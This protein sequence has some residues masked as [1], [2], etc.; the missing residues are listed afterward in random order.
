VS[1]ISTHLFDWVEKAPENI[2]RLCCPAKKVVN[3]EGE[4]GIEFS[5]GLEKG[6]CTVSSVDMLLRRGGL[7]KSQ[8]VK[9]NELKDEIHVE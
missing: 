9:M 3:E 2:K 1:V 6:V 5:Y 8:T 4:E 7:L